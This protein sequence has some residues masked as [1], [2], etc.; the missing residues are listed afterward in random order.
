MYNFK[1]RRKLQFRLLFL[2]R[3]YKKF[4][5]NM[6]I[7]LHILGDIAFDLYTLSYNF[8]T[9]VIIKVYHKW[10]TLIYNWQFE[11]ILY[12]TLCYSISLKPICKLES[13]KLM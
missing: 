7:I 11:N 8:R 1:V 4:D 6:D 3:F 9:S 10:V 12:K 2:C 5:I 13:S